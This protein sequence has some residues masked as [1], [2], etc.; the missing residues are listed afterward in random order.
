MNL[1]T[2][3]SVSKIGVSLLCA[4]GMLAGTLAL[5]SGSKGGGFGKDQHGSKAV[6]ELKFDELWAKHSGSSLWLGGWFKGLTHDK[7]EIH[8]TATFIVESKCV[9]TRHPRYHAPPGLKD[10]EVVVKHFSAT[11][12]KFVG[13]LKDKLPF[14]LHL[15]LGKHFKSNFSCPNDHNFEIVHKKRMKDLHIWV[16]RQGSKHILA[17]GDCWF[18]NEHDEHATC[19]F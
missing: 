14:D 17:T 12:S 6:D 3:R 16:T 7:L 5:A 8:V 15:D 4:A 10:T 18:A 19:S 1:T 2:Y 9:I 13:P 11:T